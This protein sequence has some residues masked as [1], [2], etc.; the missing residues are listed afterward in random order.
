MEKEVENKCVLTI[1]YEKLNVGETITDI[2][3]RN[4]AVEGK[5]D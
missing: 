3:G 5:G 4:K 2:I 1:P